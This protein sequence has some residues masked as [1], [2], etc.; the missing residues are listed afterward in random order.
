M[1]NIRSKQI[2]CE[3]LKSKI[4]WSASVALT[5]LLLL[6]ACE[7]PVGP[8]GPQGVQGPQ[9]EKGDPGEKG[10]PGNANVSTITIQINESDYSPNRS[11]ISGRVLWDEATYRVSELT[12]EVA[13]NGAVIGYLGGGDNWLVLPALGAEFGFD[14]ESIEVRIDR[15][16]EISVLGL[17]NG[18]YFRFVIIHPPRAGKLTNINIEDYEAVMD[19]LKTP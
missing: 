16:S 1:N 10:A 14:T 5:L 18:L 12:A 3:S 6:T 4:F 15:I 17:F 11:T 7:G 9:G 8:E 13:T 19:A 2:L